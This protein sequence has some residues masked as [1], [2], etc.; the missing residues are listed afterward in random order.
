VIVGIAG[1]LPTI[2][3]G[4]LRLLIRAGD[5]STIRAVLTLLSVYRVI[6]IPVQLKLGTITDPFKGQS[7]TLPKYELIKAVR[8]ITNRILVNKLRID[9]NVLQLG[10]AGPN[11]SISALGIW[12]DI[13]A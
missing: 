2:I 3:P 9:L 5:S 10:S 6:S 4:S 8:E 11:S 7:E 13:K 12:N 1:G